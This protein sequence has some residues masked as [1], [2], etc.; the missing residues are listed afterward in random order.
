MI[1]YNKLIKKNLCIIVEIFN[2]INN[3]NL[4]YLIKELISK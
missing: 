1:I 2:K 3:L 4:I